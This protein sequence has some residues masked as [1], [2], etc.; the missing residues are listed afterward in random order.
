MVGFK[1]KLSVVLLIFLNPSG[2]QVPHLDNG[3]DT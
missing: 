1:A 2:S 3:D